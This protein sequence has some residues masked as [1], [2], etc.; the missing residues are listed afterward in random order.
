MVLGAK[1][2]KGQ[3]YGTWRSQRRLGLLGQA[4]GRDAHR[5]LPNIR[6][7]PWVIV[8]RVRVLGLT[9][10]SGIPQVDPK[11]AAAVDASCT[12]V[13]DTG[14]AASESFLGS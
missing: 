11:H 7:I 6:K 14:Q 9:R 2:R 10:S 8:G 12:A 13:V 1:C 5:H 3:D 4:N